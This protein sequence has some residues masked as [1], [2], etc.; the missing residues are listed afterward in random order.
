MKH[1]N[2]KKSDLKTKLVQ[3]ML[4]LM[5]CL[6]STIYHPETDGAIEQANKMIIEVLCSYINNWHTNCVVYLTHVE[7]VFNNSV[8][9]LTGFA[10]NEL[11]YGTTV[12]LFPAFK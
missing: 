8:N 6:F 2:L 4:G 5:P 7:S 11:V 10:P 3:T 9:A 1:F 12:S